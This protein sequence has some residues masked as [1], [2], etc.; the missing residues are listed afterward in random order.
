MNELQY[1]S[2]VSGS[3]ALD[4]DY[5]ASQSAAPQDAF[6]LIGGSY[7]DF[8][9]RR[10]SPADWMRSRWSITVDALGVSEMITRP[11]SIFGLE[12]NRR[13]PVWAPWCAITALAIV[14][15]AFV[16]I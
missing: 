11:T 6:T 9:D 3:S 2:Y 16:L 4:F 7:G 13:M 14:S 12:Q 10:L 8:E 15:I 5:F 1:G